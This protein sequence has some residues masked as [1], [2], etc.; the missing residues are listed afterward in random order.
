MAFAADSSRAFASVSPAAWVALGR[1]D[2]APST[3]WDFPDQGS[4]AV[5]FGDP[6]FNGVTPAQSVMNLVRRYSLPGDLVIDP[7]AGSGTVLDVARLLGRRSIGFDLAPR[8]KDLGRADARAWPVR[9]GIAALAI[10]DS[11]YSDNV[12]YSAD[13]GCLGRIPCRDPRFYE[14]MSRVAQEAHRVLR[15]GGILAW[16]ISDE[17]RAGIYT[18]VGFR[19]FYVL[20]QKFEPVDTISLVRHHDRSGSPMWEH[21]ARRYNFFL[22]GFKFLLIVRKVGSVTGGMEYGQRIGS[23]E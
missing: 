5:A 6:G 18:P 17:Y 11:P 4:G 8:R 22:R 1:A 10:I 19:M 23:D 21:R 12:R 9:D 2:L 15:S 20:T 7:M 13:E 14:E 16:I 3:C